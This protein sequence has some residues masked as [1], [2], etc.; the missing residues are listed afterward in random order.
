MKINTETGLTNGIRRYMMC[1][2]SAKKIKYGNVSI[3]I[4]HKF[5]A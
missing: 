1:S 3:F 4:M 2:Q 5:E